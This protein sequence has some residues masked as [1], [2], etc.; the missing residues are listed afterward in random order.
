MAVFSAL[1]AQ[2]RALNPPKLTIRNRTVR[3]M[4]GDYVENVRLRIERSKTLAFH[5]QV[6][7]DQSRNLIND[8]RAW[9]DLYRLSLKHSG[10]PLANSQSQL[11]PDDG[12]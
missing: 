1:L 9:F 6:A 4:V 11:R 3:A 5:A 12:G 8:C 2:L 7:L 10:M